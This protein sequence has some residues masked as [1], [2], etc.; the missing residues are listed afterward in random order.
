MLYV[1]YISIKLREKTKWDKN[2]FWLHFNKKKYNTSIWVISFWSCQLS[3]SYFLPLCKLQVTDGYANFILSDKDL[4]DFLSHCGRTIFGIYLWTGINSI[5]LSKLSTYTKFI[6]L[7][8]SFNTWLY[9]SKLTFP[10]FL[11][12]TL[13]ST[14]TKT[15]Q[16]DPYTDSRSFI[17]G[18]FSRI[19]NSNV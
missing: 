19:W 9:L 17:A 14:R 16:L 18:L 11:S 5:M 7:S 6:N 1:N 12:P 15:W 10:G 13:A 2:N 3:L 4:I 8:V